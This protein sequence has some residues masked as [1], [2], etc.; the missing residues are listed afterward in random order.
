MGRQYSLS[1]LI[2]LLLFT[3]LVTFLSSLVGLRLFQGPSGD[4]RAEAALFLEAREVI[5]NRYVG[6]IADERY[7]TYAAI[8][9]AVR[10]LEDPWSRYL[11]AEEHAQHLQNIER[12]QRR[13]GLHFV[14]DEETYEML[15]I[16][17]I[18]GSP[19]AE[20]GLVPGDTI[21]TLEGD[22]VA[23]MEIAEFRETVTAHYGGSVRL[24]VRDEEGGLR[25]VIVR[26]VGAV[27]YQLL[28]GDVGYIRITGFDEGSGEESIEAI[29]ALLS[30]GAQSLIFDLRYNPG[31]RLRDL[32]LLLDYLLPEGELFVFADYAGRE[33]VQYA[34]S[35]YLCMPM[36]VLVNE[37]SASA[38]EYFAA[39]LQ[40]KDWATI[41]GTPTTGKGRSQVMIPLSDGSAILLSTNRYLTPGRVDLYE[42]GGIRPDYHV[43]IGEEGGDRQLERALTLV[44]A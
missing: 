3:V 26:V 23:Q 44:G 27:S 9:A 13:I 7:L 39:I 22:D 40:E 25:E 24:G 16:S 15:V 29:E 37:N 10:A 1:T 34:G 38:A 30:E 33:S 21:V 43:E 18:P 28:A 31:G 2:V 19:A 4:L 41:V 14:R 12:P 32:L 6:E 20:A 42:T 5:S 36:V 11:T 8:A 35:D 17:V